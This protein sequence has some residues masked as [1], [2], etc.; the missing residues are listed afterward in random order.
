[1]NT[2]K[3]INKLAEVDTKMSAKIW[4]QANL[5]FSTHE[6]IKSIVRAISVGCYNEEVRRIYS[7]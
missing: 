2:I 7:G 5:I 6:M 4:S 3:G 1:M